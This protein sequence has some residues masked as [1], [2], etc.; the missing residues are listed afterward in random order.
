MAICLGINDDIIKLFKRY[1]E[2][3]AKKRPEPFLSSFHTDYVAYNLNYSEDSSKNDGGQSYSGFQINTGNKEVI[4]NT[5]NKQV[6]NSGTNVKQN[7]N[8][9]LIDF[10]FVGGSG[11]NS[12][13][14]TNINNTT[15][16]SGN[17]QNK[18]TGNQKMG[19]INDIFD[20]FK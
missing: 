19:D 1:D 12:N 14:N 9:N 3:K 8:S 18:N 11:N 2:L 5:G 17:N 20:A 15:G 4:N 13:T 7:N 6:N 16:N 10:D